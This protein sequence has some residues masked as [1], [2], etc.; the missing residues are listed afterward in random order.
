MEAMSGMICGS[1]PIV[2]EVVTAIAEL[3]RWLKSGIGKAISMRN[4]IVDRR[5]TS[6]VSLTVLAAMFLI[7]AATGRHS[8]AFYMLLRLIVTVGAVYWAWNVYEMGLRGW[9]W[10]FASVALLMNPFV[11]IRMRRS[12]WQPI[13]L[14]LGVLLLCWSVFWYFRRPHKP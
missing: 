14:G 6:E 11:P 12:D 5:R 2:N 1:V 9:V 10:I 3:E 13:D 4:V 7:V 8:Y